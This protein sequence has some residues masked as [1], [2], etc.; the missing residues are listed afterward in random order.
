MGV[1]GDDA[2]VL[3]V[4]DSLSLV[5]PIPVMNSPQCSGHDAFENHPEK[6]L[7]G[8]TKVCQ[9]QEQCP[10]EV[11]IMVVLGKKSGCS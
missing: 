2:I 4:W 3:D 11:V 8:I 10:Q 5:K 1:G 7:V 6:G 9:R